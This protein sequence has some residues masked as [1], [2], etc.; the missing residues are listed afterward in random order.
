MWNK[1]AGF[2][3]LGLLIGGGATA[4]LIYLTRPPELHDA[5]VLDRAITQG[6]KDADD[7]AA[8]LRD[9]EKEVIRRQEA[10]SA[11]VELAAGQKFINLREFAPELRA[12]APQIGGGTEYML[13]ASR[14]GYKVLAWSPVCTVIRFTHPEMVDPVRDPHAIGCNHFGFWNESG[15]HF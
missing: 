14:S 5:A 10:D 6:R 8:F 4:A 15:A 9:V 13:R 3:A 12:R 11:A 7:A 2:F 1:I